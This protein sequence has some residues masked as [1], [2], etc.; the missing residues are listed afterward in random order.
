MMSVSASEARDAAAE[1][2]EAAERLRNTTRGWRV[3]VGRL[4]AAFYGTL[5][6]M[7]E[8]V[9]SGRWTQVE[10]FEYNEFVARI[11]SYTSVSRYIIEL[12]TELRTAVVICDLPLKN[13]H[14]LPDS[15]GFYD[16]KEIAKCIQKYCTD[17][18]V[19]SMVRNELDRPD[20]I[21]RHTVIGKGLPM[22]TLDIDTFSYAVDNG[23]LENTKR[24]PRN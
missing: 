7:W 23:N 17:R 5:D 14:E 2:I 4:I 10:N 19:M 20:E 22:L 1:V 18:E 13:Y 9:I 3:T 24:Y 11:N 21:P 15:V 8:S 16:I 6:A 12:P